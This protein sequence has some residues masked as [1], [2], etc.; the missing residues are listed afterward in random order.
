M[1]AKLNSVTAKAKT[2]LAAKL[3]PKTEFSK[4]IKNAHPVIMG[5]LR[6][7]YHRLSE[8]NTQRD[9]SQ[10][11]IEKYTLMFKNSIENKEE[12]QNK[13]DTIKQKLDKNME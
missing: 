7:T 3:I 6:S 8:S 1:Q 12:I 11:E 13:I 5:M 10:E 2:H 9:Y 4:I